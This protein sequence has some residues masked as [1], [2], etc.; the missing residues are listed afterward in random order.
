MI[1]RVRLVELSLLTEWEVARDKV[2]KSNRMISRW[3]GE[4]Y[5]FGVYKGWATST[6]R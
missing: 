6:E 4:A 2:V 3:C 5:R 1:G